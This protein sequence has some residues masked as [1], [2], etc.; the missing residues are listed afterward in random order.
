MAP[1]L[2]LVR[3]VRPR[4]GALLGLAFGLAYFGALLWWIERFGQMAWSALTIA[5]A[6]F[7]AAFGLLAPVIWRRDRPIRS[8]VGLRLG[9]NL[10]Y[11]KFTDRPTWNP[12]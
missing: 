10:G 5:S 2:W 8:G 12:F 11:L 9:A 7:V 4:R 3:R 1:F 6:V